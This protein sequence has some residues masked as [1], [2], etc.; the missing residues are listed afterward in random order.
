MSFE[1]PCCCCSLGL[2]WILIITVFI[3]IV[4][5]YVLRTWWYFNDRNVKYVRGM[6]LLGTMYSSMCGLD[7][8][9]EHS[10]KLYERFP[11]ERFFGM[12]DM[13]GKTSY[14]LRDPELIRQVTIT[15]FD[16]FVNHRF[17]FDEEGD[18]MLGRALFGMRDEKWRQMRATMS[19]AFTGSKMRLMHVLMVE[20]AKDFIGSLR[21]DVLGG[22][23]VYETKDL[24]RKYACD[25]IG[26]CAFGIKINSLEDANNAFYKAGCEIP[27]FDGIKGLKFLA[28]ISMPAVLKFF[29]IKMISD[30]HASFFRSVILENIEQRIRN[31][32]VRND[33]IDLL[34]KAKNGTLSHND[35]QEEADNKIGFATV[36]ESSTGKSSEKRTGM[37]NLCS[38]FD[39]Y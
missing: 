13:L 17:E 7:S 31:G 26:T 1:W 4:Y 15:D 10:Q 16:H 14:F 35:A 37:F 38:I 30:E 19:P 22:T 11:N 29:K 28:Y 32:I 33:M 27:N 3:C 25:I 9:A 8:E 23:A 12:Y 21:Q 39:G 20:T 5:Q 18:P 2:H 6:P 24:F 36:S 34:I